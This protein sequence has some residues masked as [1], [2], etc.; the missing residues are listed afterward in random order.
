M[1]ASQRDQRLIKNLRWIARIWTIP[2]LVFAC[3][4][5][6]SPSS[7]SIAACLPRDDLDMGMMG[8]IVL[9]LLLAW[10][11]EAL[12]GFLALV[13]IAAHYVTYCVMI[14]PTFPRWAI[15]LLGV[16]AVLFMVCAG[17]SHPKLKK[18]QSEESRE[19]DRDGARE[20]HS[21]G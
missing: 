2:I 16:P 10:R 7:R 13:G 3:G 6:L 1:G 12:G 9:G 5:L 18:E 17:L 20:S 11:W 19:D 15:A 8:I 14:G 21:W 4:Q